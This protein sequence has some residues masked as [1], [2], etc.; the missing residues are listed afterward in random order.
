[1]SDNRKRKNALK[2]EMLELKHPVIFTD[3]YRIQGCT[4]VETKPVDIE[5]VKP[6]A[7]YVNNMGQVFNNKGQ[8]IKP[9][10]INSGYYNF[11]MVTG[12]KNGPKYKHV[13]AHRLVKSTFDPIENPQDH[14]IDHKNMNKSDNRL[15]NLAWKSQKENNDAKY[16]NSNLGGVNNYNSLFTFEELRVI[17]DGIIKGKRYAQILVEIDKPVTKIYKD[18]IG[19]IKRGITYKKEVSIILGG[20]VQRLD[21]F[22]RRG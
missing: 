17:V 18:Y 21:S 15:S 3:K 14:T 5:G 6:G 11:R 9:D 12:N 13:L 7:Y 4:F 19:N 10:K 16:Q 2:G 20:D 1:M 22:Y 8:E